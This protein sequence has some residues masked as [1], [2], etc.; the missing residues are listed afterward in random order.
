MASKNIFDHECI[1]CGTMFPSGKERDYYC[2][3]CKSKMELVKKIEV[4][5]KAELDLCK[6]FNKYREYSKMEH[7]KECANVV[8]KRVFDGVDN[9]GSKPEAIIAI[10]MINSGITYRSQAQ[11]GKNKVDFL[12]P[13][14]KIILE[15]DGFLYHMNEDKTFVRDRQIMSSVGEEWEIVHISDDSIPNKTWNIDITLP[16]VVSQR[17]EN[18]RFRDTRSDDYFLNM[19]I[20]SMSGGR[21]YI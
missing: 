12:L 14:I 18:G 8:R 17:N 10:Q 4:V 7:I 9:F 2:D 3:D 1:L 21:K 19:A 6:R 5:D 15:V 20:Y 16:M 13:K 11:V